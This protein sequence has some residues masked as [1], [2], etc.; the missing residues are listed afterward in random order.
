MLNRA[1]KVLKDQ[2][3]WIWKKK[4]MMKKR[5]QVLESDL[6]FRRPILFPFLFLSFPFWPKHFF[7]FLCTSTVHLLRP[8]F[9]SLLFLC[10]VYSPGRQKSF[11]HKIEC[12]VVGYKREDAARKRKRGEP[13]SSFF[14][15][16]FHCQFFLAFKINV[17]EL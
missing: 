14:L 13:P 17:V 1:N 11:P 8:S 12:R 10:V 5:N 4:D 3:F 6:D 9:S 2:E 15:F 7:S 16:S